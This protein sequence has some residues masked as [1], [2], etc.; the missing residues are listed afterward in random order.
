MAYISTAPPWLRFFFGKCTWDIPSG[1]KTIYLSFDDGPHPSITEFVLNELDKYG[2]KAT[3]FCIGRNVERYPAIFESIIAGGHTVGNHTYSHLNGWKTKTEV[4][5]RDILE[6]RKLINSDLFR[7]P[8]GRITRKQHKFLTSR[9]K[10][11][12][13]IMW[14]VLSGDFD[15]GITPEQCCNNV[16]KNARSGSVVVFHDSDRA[17]DRMRYALP[18]VLKHFTDKGYLFKKIEQKVIRNE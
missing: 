2:A 3:F 13:V 11:F 15:G 7:P 14:S 5:S 1:E 16:L 18:V 17:N 9:E 10:P 6:A 12:K 8:Y 4:Y